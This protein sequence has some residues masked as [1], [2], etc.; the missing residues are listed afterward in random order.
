MLLDNAP[1]DEKARPPARRPPVVPVPQL[2]IALT[3]VP[4]SWSN[5]EILLGQISVCLRFLAGAHVFEAAEIH[6]R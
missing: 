6:I 5:S 2:Q 3:S 4:A 1:V